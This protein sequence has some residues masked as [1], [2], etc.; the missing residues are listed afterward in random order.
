M[1]DGG[2]YVGA[3][4]F[5]DWNRGGDARGQRGV[6]ALELGGRVAAAMREEN[7]Q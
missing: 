5:S 7:D 4:Y 3:V 2:M 6:D 1:A